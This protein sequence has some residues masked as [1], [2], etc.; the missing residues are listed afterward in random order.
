MPRHAPRPLRLLATAAAVAALALS[1]ACA[2]SGSSATS[3]PATCPPATPA[4]GAV[5]AHPFVCV[6]TPTP[7]TT[8]GRAVAVA[9]R[10]ANF[11]PF[12]VTVDLIDG[13]GL[14]ATSGVAE[15][16]DAGAAGHVRAWRI[17]LS[18]PAG[19]EPGEMTLVARAFDRQHRTLGEHDVPVVL[20]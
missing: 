5:A 1:A 11:G 16:G 2:P 19:V 7:G 12:R 17:A 9:G 20:R 13:S 15:F 6:D 10:A 4:A 14:I 8:V 3:G 18:V